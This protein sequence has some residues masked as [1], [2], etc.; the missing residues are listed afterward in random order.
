MR[1]AI[2]ILNFIGTIGLS[3]AQK[4]FKSLKRYSMVIPQGYEQI[5]KIG[6]NVEFTG[7]S[8]K[9]INLGISQIEAKN[10]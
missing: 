10:L 6:S 9:I 3:N 5:N 1:T 8:P 4:T 2:I 7:V